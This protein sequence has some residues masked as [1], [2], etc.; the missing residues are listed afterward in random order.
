MTEITTRGI[1]IRGGNGDLCLCVPLLS[2]PDGV[3]VEV[4]ED[5]IFLH[6][7]WD[8]GPL[9]VVGPSA[10]TAHVIAGCGTILLS[11]VPQGVPDPK[12]VLSTVQVLPPAPAPRR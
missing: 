7:G 6:G 8:G 5:A 1:V 9:R 3:H 2:V 4:S 10:A 11:Q 12:P